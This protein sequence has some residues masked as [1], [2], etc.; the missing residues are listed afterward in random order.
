MNIRW[1]SRRR[2]SKS[3][4]RHS[5]FHACNV[6]IFAFDED[7]LLASF[8]SKPG[9]NVQVQLFEPLVDFFESVGGRSI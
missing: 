3:G 5:L 4:Q 6:F 2:P 8:V 7:R 1:H 9:A